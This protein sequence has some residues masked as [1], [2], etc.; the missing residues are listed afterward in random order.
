MPE[1]RLR[2]AR[3]RGDR[4][5]SLVELL[6]SMTLFATAMA[7]IMGA[8]IEVLHVT[9][10]A[11]GA[12]ASV[13]NTRQ[14][15]AMIDRQVR[16]GNV[17]FSPADEALHVSTCQDLGALQG[18]CMRIFTQSNGSEKCVQWQVAPSATGGTHE[19]RMRSWSPTWQTTGGVSDWAVVARGLREPTSTSAPFVLDVGP[20]GIYGERLLRV[21]LV[22]IN[23]ASGKDVS[24]D[25]SISGRNTTYGYTG[26]ECL[27][28]PA[29]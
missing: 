17:L 22:A 2:R 14:A 18:S 10:D 16:S 25:A 21:H 23:E 7:L 9:K 11:E 12:A 19:L 4:G 6:V 1:I 27:P 26:S 15:L 3:P 13:Q 5:T 29:A 24:L 8:A 20:A 28:V